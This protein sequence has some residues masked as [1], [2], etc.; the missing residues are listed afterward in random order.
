M[1]V[2]KNFINF[3]KEILFGELGTLIGIQ[4]VDFLSSK[5]S[6]PVNLIPHIIV[7]GAM[8]GGSLFW[9]LARVYYKSKEEGYSEKKFFNDIEYFAPASSLFS[10][11]FYY[12]V[13][14][15]A[16]KYFL[17]HHRQIEFST[18]IPQILAFF[19][20]VVGIN[21]YRYILLKVKGKNL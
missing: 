20:F 9:L 14:F 11:I 4:F 12:P 21:I 18:I 5:F 7:L 6:F 16:T 13:L 19:A 17:A 15:F 3:N 1:K 2:S 10:F 8:I